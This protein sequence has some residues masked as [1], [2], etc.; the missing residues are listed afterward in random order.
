[1]LTCAA[2]SQPHA[3]A[4]RRCCGAPRGPGRRRRARGVIEMPAGL[5]VVL[6]GRVRRAPDGVLTGGSPRRAMRLSA[7]GRR[8][9]HD[10]ERGEQT[11]AAVL[12]LARRLVDDGLA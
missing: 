1:M 2:W 4:S 11:D 12:R 7:A 8:A 3:W 10:L 5:R 6:D 9:L